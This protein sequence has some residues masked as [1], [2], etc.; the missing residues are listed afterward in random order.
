[1]TGRPAVVA[2]HVIGTRAALGV[3]VSRPACGPD[4]AGPAR[5]WYWRGRRL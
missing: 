3:A 2:F 5:P 1:M 4:Q